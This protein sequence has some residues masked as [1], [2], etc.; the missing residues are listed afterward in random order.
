MTMPNF[1]DIDLGIIAIAVVVIVFVIAESFTDVPAPAYTFGGLAITA[2]AALVRG[3][4]R[5]KSDD[6]GDVESPR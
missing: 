6:G 5:V 2:I 4:K 1:D 3:T